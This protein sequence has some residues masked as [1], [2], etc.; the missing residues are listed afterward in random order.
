MHRKQKMSS[1][2]GAGGSVKMHDALEALEREM[3][4]TEELEL[5][6]KELQRTVH[7]AQ[8]HAKMEFLAAIA[9]ISPTAIFLLKKTPD[10]E[11]LEMLKSS[12]NQEANLEQKDSL[13]SKQVSAPVS[14]SVVPELTVHARQPSHEDVIKAVL[15]KSQSKQ[16]IAHSRTHSQLDADKLP[17]PISMSVGLSAVDIEKKEVGDAAHHRAQSL[18][19]RSV[20]RIQDPVDDTKQSHLRVQS[21]DS[22]LHVLK[23]FEVNPLTFSLAPDV[24][25]DLHSLQT[26]LPSVSGPNLSPERIVPVAIDLGLPQH[27]VLDGMPQDANA[28]TVIT[29]DTETEMG[30]QQQVSP[31]NR[32]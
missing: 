2:T 13:Q 8:A 17:A 7:A 27:N 1:G 18:P 15:G 16:S 10:A 9:K 19:V 14:I 12:L 4:K 28:L 3:K 6:N 22:S 30:A 26:S 31:S 21:G 20:A 23:R 25:T 24:R 32:S 5:K 29:V 11:L